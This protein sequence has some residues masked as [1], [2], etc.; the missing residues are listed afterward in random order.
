MRHEYLTHSWCMKHGMI[1]TQITLLLPCHFHLQQPHQTLI[2]SQQQKTT[3]ASTWGRIMN[4]VIGWRNKLATSPNTLLKT[5]QKQ[6]PLLITCFLITQQ[7]LTLLPITTLMFPHYFHPNSV[8]EN[9]HVYLDP[10]L[11]PSPIMTP[12]TSIF[13]FKQIP[14]L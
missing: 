3:I 2:Q 11:S 10:S 5:F 14:Q 7:G 4:S 6:Q 1:T 12:Q 9:P 13:T 8:K